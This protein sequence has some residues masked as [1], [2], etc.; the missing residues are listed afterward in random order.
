VL[1]VMLLIL[2]LAIDF[3]RA[4]YGW[5]VLQNSA[6]IAANYAAL[7]PQ[8][9]QGG[10]NAVLQADYEQLIE[11]DQG[12][13]N[14]VAPSMPPPPVFLD[15]PDTADIAGIPDSAYDIGDTVA[16]SLVC[17]FTPLTPLI[18]NIV[19]TPVALGARAEFR[20]R[21]GDIVGMPNATRIP[22]PSPSPGSSPSSAPS[23]PPSPSPS[24]ACPTVSITATNDSNQGQPH[25]WD[26]AGSVSDATS[27]W[28]WAWTGDVVASTQN[29]NNH[30]FPA[31]DTYSIT[32]TATKGSCAPT[33]TQQVVVP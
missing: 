5:V 18:G 13:A 29:V 30:D 31:A 2:L 32:L 11:N 33:A 17:N 15:G 10:G 1:P 9:W 27:G 28:L 22:A 3:G 20:I 12:T 8:A 14:C 24:P 26:F 23:S 4:L 16:V 21:A 7:Y 6:R 19:G 25:R